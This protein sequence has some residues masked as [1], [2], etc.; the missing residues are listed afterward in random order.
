M[1]SLSKKNYMGWIRDY[2]SIRD[3]TQDHDELSTKHKQMGINSTV[4]S[5]LKKVG[6]SDNKTALEVAVSL[7]EYFSPVEDQ[8]NLGSC[9]ANAAAGVVEYFENRAFGKYT[10]ASRLFIYKTTRNLMNET[11]DTGAFLRSTM[12]AL[13]IFGVI[14]EE[15]YPYNVDNFDSEPS[16]FHYAYAQNF[17]SI[18]YY[19]LDPIGTSSNELLNNIKVHVSKGIPS[20]FGF[21]V[22]ESYVDAGKNGKIPYPSKNEKIVGGHAIV[23]AGYDDN[24][25]II[26]KRGKK[27]TK[28]ALLIRNSWGDQWGLDGYGWLPYDYVINGLAVD[29]WVL[30]KNEWIETA[31]FTN[32]D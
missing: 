27:E 17:Q 29:F 26:N 18:S 20:M 32:E 14:P 15:Y 11:G 19:R 16:S 3:Y 8:K 25:T 9:T 30:I 22:Y 24:I 10:N 5:M 6:V 7:K 2:P 13:A 28:G 4:K 12:G 21:T 1:Q 23:V 31:D